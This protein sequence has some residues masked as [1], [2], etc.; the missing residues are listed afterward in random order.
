MSRSILI[1]VVGW[2]LVA[3]VTQAQPDTLIYTTAFEKRQVEAALREGKPDLVSLFSALTSDSASAQT[4]AARIERFYTRVQP[5]LAMLRS[6][7]Q[8]AK[9]IFKEVHANFFKQYEENVMFYKIFDNGIYNCVTASMLYAIVLDHYQIPYEIKEKPTHIYLVALPG[10]ENILF[11]TTNPR[12]LYVPD[13]RFK[14][15]FVNNL[16]ETKF[17]TQTYVNSIGLANAFNEFYYNNDKISL[18]QLAGVQYYN[19]SLDYYSNAKDQPAAIRSA[20]KMYKL[21]PCAKHALFKGYLIRA[22]LDNSLYDQLQD[23]LYLC[24]FA[25]TATDVKDEKFVYGTFQSMFDAKLYKEGNDTL[26]YQA[27]TILQSNLSSEK[28]LKEISYIY[29]GNMGA[30][31][32]DKGDLEQSLEY[33][34]KAYAINPKDSRL[35]DMIARSIVLKSD[36]LRGKEAAISTL[37]AYAEKFTFLKS[38]KLFQSMMVAQYAFRA[39]GLFLENSAT[40]GYKYLKLMEESLDSSGEKMTVYEDLLGMAYAEAGAYHYRKKEFNKAREILKKGL[41]YYP[42]HGELK[43]RLKIVED[44][45]R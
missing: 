17:T 41:D 39:Y 27:F 4:Y 5:Q 37:H 1:M 20:L 9:Y 18:V 11:E 30:W 15:E 31:R 21:Y 32:F 42:D 44:E 12:G 45:I 36:K 23:V 2:A 33:G 26:M 24:E 19:Q 40:D 25:N 16:I 34:E 6:P 43:E 13:E 10:T 28:I 22:A 29:Y 8:K 35:Q 14:R 3:L 7:K 38:N